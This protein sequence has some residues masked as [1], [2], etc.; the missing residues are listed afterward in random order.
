MKEQ[1]MNLKMP[2]D[3]YEKLKEIAAKK[4]LTLAGYVR[5][6]LFEKIEEESK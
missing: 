4:G 3:A 5:M 1:L 2:L 6:I